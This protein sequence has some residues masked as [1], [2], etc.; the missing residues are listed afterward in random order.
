MEIKIISG[1]YSIVEDGKVV[2]VHLTRKE[3]EEARTPSKPKDKPKTKL[4]KKT[5]KK[6]Q[7]DL[8]IEES[9]IDA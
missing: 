7:D 5:K 3:A 8:L 1:K 2:S 6:K 4:K 9:G